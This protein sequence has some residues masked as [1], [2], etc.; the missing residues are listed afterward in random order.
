MIA[1]RVQG[2]AL[3]VP[4]LLIFLAVIAG[5]QIAGI[6]GAILAVPALAILRALWVFFD[7]RLVVRK[8]AHEA[9]ATAKATANIL[10]SGIAGRAEKPPAI[11]VEVTSGADGAETTRTVTVTKDG[12]PV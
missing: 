5:S 6:F 4:P 3:S 9:Y 2:R 10:V 12:K 1:P 8:D 11:S 7:Q